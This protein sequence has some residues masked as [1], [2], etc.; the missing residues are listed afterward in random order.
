MKV[1][2]KS[3]VV[4]GGLIAGFL[5]PVAEA[6][7]LVDSS[8]TEQTG[9]NHVNLERNSSYRLICRVAPQIPTG[10]AGIDTSCKRRSDTFENP[11]LTDRIMS[12]PGMITWETSKVVKDF[13]EQEGWVTAQYVK[14]NTT[15][16]DWSTLPESYV[17]YWLD[18]KVRRD[19]PLGAS[20]INYTGDSSISGTGGSNERGAFSDFN[21][22]I[23]YDTTPPV[24]TPH[25]AAGYYAADQAI[26]IAVN[27]T[28]STVFYAINGDADYAE[29]TS[30]VS[31][32][33]TEESCVTYDLWMKSVDSP[34]EEEPNWE[35]PHYAKYVID[36]EAPSMSNFSAV[37]EVSGMGGI[38]SVG[39]HVEDC[40]GVL[41]N[42]GRPNYVRLGGKAME[43]VSGDDVGYF[44]Y[45][46]EIDGTEED[47]PL[48]EV[49]VTD[50]AGNFSVQ[51]IADLV[52][53]DLVGPEFTITPDPDPVFLEQLLKIHI[54]ANKT[55]SGEKPLVT[56]GE[57]S[58][59]YDRDDSDLINYYFVKL[60]TGRGW[61]ASLAQLDPVDDWDEDGLPNWWESQFGLDPH[62]SD[63][64]NGA[65]GDPD[66]D[67]WNNQQEYQFYEM[68][69]ELIN[70]TDAASGGQ[71]IP[72]HRGWNLISYTVNTV[73][74]RG[75]VAPTGLLDGVSKVRI[76]GDSWG[77]FFSAARFKGSASNMIAA[78][79]KHPNGEW[80]YYGNFQ[81]EYR[82]SLDYISP[83]EGLWINMKQADVL[84]LKGN[85]VASSKRVIPDGGNTYPSI[86]LNSGWN[87]VGILPQTRFYQVGWEPD[88]ST[89]SDLVNSRVYGSVRAT[90]MAAFNFNETEFDKIAAIQVMYS[91]GIKAYESSVPERYQSLRY[92]QPGSGAWIRVKD[93]QSTVLK[94]REP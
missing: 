8:L 44:W 62:R 22:I 30:P 60:M 1:R 54:E 76:E 65:G 92:V 35:T 93:G 88:I 89:P 85:S 71:A 12:I 33:G 19:A 56:V 83:G 94:Y 57:E 13:D 78:Q 41:S 63:G 43:W 47:P 87:L 67:G 55:L 79:V 66:G 48:L 34:T 29:Y 10:I 6:S 59:A 73:W 86:T 74:Y 49:K 7:A 14:A 18:L 58:A 38:V 70:P 4:V 16:D 36:R 84:I 69:G 45:Q 39:F 53:F 31:L 15:G 51:T 90:L 11:V 52:A 50:R 24:T 32:T 77:E 17:L 27:E 75:S 91:N 20:N 37:P 64:N 68:T 46:R 25:P 21:Y 42:Q 82:S 26:T 72:L 81:A 61:E 80:K 3:L 28:P 5:F 2:I 9:G 40:S 23:T